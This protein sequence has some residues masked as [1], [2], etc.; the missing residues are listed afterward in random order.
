MKTKL[1]NPLDMINS[2]FKGDLCTISYGGYDVSD[3]RLEELIHL[4]DINDRAGIL[5]DIQ[6]LIDAY[7]YKNNNNYEA[8][9]RPHSFYYGSK[10]TDAI[11]NAIYI[12]GYPEV[13]LHNIYRLFNFNDMLIKSLINEVKIIILMKAGFDKVNLNSY[14]NL[15][16]NVINKLNKWKQEK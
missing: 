15:A 1:T 3:N 2:C 8:E 9:I 4:K 11:I 12:Y 5:D 10:K 13:A 16:I 14:N 6:D 7:V